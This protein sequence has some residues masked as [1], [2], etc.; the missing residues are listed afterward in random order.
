[1]DVGASPAA[2]NHLRLKLESA[3][4]SVE[5]VEMTAEE[6]ALRAG[7]DED[8]ASHIAMVA[9][10]AAVNAVKHGNGWSAEKQVDVGFELTE[11]A[12]TIKVADEGP[13]LDVDEVEDCREPDN[14]LRTSGRGIF[15]M[16]A[17]MDEVH[18]RKLTP[19]TEITMVKCRTE[20]ETEA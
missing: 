4:E 10:E 2:K 9:R 1:M 3:L 13:G 6:F 8:T 15:L 19:G 7:F 20:K 5:L 17:I 11:R 18:F 14:L 16:K 12:L